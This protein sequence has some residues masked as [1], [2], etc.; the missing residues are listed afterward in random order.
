VPASVSLPPDGESD[1]PFEPSLASPESIEWLTVNGTP[2]D[3]DSAHLVELGE[4]D[5]MAGATAFASEGTPAADAAQ[6]DWEIVVDIGDEMEMTGTL[7]ALD[8]PSV[9]MA[10]E[11]PETLEVVDINDLTGMADPFDVEPVETTDP[12]DL[13]LVE[14]TGQIDRQPAG[15]PEEPDAGDKAALIAELIA[16]ADTPS[17]RFQAAVQLGR[18]FLQRGD[19]GRGIEWLEQAC[20]VTAPVR[21]HG[22]LARYDLADALERAG[23]HARALD[24]LS[25]L[26]MDAGSYRDVSTRITRLS[27]AT[28]SAP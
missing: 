25:D 14:I 6:D 22:L 3:G 28:G 2:T 26:E 11:A 27:R 9:A 5:L 24:V 19:L 23:E 21:D 18:L 12:F 20:G 8:A 1:V 17:L 10:S 16:A 13:E 4:A 7:E 15:E